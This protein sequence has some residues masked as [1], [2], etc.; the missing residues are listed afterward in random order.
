MF[1]FYTRG[2]EQSNEKKLKERIVEL[3]AD[4]LFTAGIFENAQNCANYG[5]DVWLY[6]FDYSEPSG[7]GPQR[8]F[9]SFVGA[10]HATDLRYILGEGFYSEFKPTDDEIK[11]I[12][13]ITEIYSNFGKY[14][15]P[16]ETGSQ[17]WERYNPEHQ[18]RHYRI[19]YPRGNMRD[20]Y[21]PERM[22]YLKEVRKNNKNLETVVYGRS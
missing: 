22:E 14:G 17:E 3:F 8:E 9:A 12:D 6:V 16:N 19:S 5:N 18:R 13:K 2:V 4:A 20:E 15:N 11:M 10:T 1:D 7:F 21:C